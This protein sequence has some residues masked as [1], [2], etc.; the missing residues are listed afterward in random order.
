MFKISS[1]RWP[2]WVIWP[3]AWA[4]MFALDGTISLGNLA[5]VLVL[6]SAVAAL[7]SAAWVATFSSVLSVVLFNVFFV[8]PK[9]TFHVDLLHDYFLLMTLLGVSVVV[10]SLVFKLRHAI[11]QE[12]ILAAQSLSLERER[13]EAEQRAKQATAEAQTQKLRNTL[14]TAIAHDYRTPLANLMGAASAMREQSEQ[15]SVGQRQ[16]WAD[17]ILDEAEQLNRMTTNTLQLARLDALTLDIRKD[18]ESIQEL[19]GSVVHK[20]RRRHPQMQLHVQLADA[21]PLLHCDAVLIVQ[22]LDN[23]IENACKHNPSPHALI[24]VRAWMASAT[25]VVVVVKDQGRGIPDAYKSSVFDPFVRGVHQSHNDPANGP[26][27]V[28]R[29]GVG[30]GLAVCRAIARVHQARIWVEDVHPHGTAMCV[31]FPVPTQP[32]ALSSE[33]AV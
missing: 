9:F 3:S 33:E 13:Q 18:W 19:V 5:L 22:L 29:Q 15:A 21:L 7:W 8:P 31:A 30:L 16:V 28:A 32:Q 11:E 24:E 23:L 20:A 4:L 26:D 10:S 25:E 6:A 2:A 12:R 1:H 27:Q 14:L 17:T